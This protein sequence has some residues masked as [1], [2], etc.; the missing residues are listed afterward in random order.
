MT[1]IFKNN[2]KAMKTLKKNDIELRF[3]KTLSCSNYFEHFI[4]K[5]ISA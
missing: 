3:R 2:V 1:D 5:I 4:S